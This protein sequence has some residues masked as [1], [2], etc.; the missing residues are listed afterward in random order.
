MF[1]SPCVRGVGVVPSPIVLCAIAL[2]AVVHSTMLVALVGHG[3]RLCRSQ[4]TL[5]RKKTPPRGGALGRIP[6]A[7]ALWPDRWRWR[8][9]S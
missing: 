5:E 4:A 6:F 1:H 3:V 9:R 2:R 7:I 8:I